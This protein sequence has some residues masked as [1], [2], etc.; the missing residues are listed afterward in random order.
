MV[1]KCVI[2]VAESSRK[3]MSDCP[4]PVLLMNALGDLTTAY[5]I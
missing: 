2:F 5:N 3:N 4:T 1:I